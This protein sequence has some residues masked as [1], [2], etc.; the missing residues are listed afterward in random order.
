VVKLWI[1][2]NDVRPRMH[3]SLKGPDVCAV[4]AFDGLAWRI[5]G[6]G[7][8]DEFDW[9]LPVAYLSW[10][11]ALAGVFRLRML[12]VDRFSTLK[13]V[14]EQAQVFGPYNIVEFLRRKGCVS[15]KG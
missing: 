3:P 7:D 8:G 5:F 2:L 12:G 4:R 9:V 11:D 6:R 15:T 14:H 1:A 10:Q 13:D